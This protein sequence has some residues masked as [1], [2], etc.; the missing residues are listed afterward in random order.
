NGEIV[1]MPPEGEPHAYYASTIGDYLRGLLGDC[2]QVRES[3]PITIPAAQSEPEP[4][5]AVVQSLGKE[6]LHHH[7]YPENIFWLIEFSNTSLKKDSD[8]KAKAYAAAEIAEY[9][10]VNLQ[11]MELLV[12]RNPVSGLYQLQIMLTSGN[13]TPL[14]FPD[15]AISVRRLLDRDKQDSSPT[16]VTHL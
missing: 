1:E 14:A 11:K 5:L 7:P 13:V 15:I 9:W 12:M 2:A 3:H 4:D 8:P 6:Y 10:I 16:G